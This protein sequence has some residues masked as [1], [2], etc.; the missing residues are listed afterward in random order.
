MSESKTILYFLRNGHMGGS[1]RQTLYLAQGLAGAGYRM[2]CV[3][4]NEGECAERMR[5]YGPVHILDLPPWRSVQ[6]VLK[7][8]RLL[9]KLSA[10]V[11]QYRPLLVH[12]ADV[13]LTPYAVNMARILGI[14]SIVHVRAPLAV[15]D[16]CK[17]GCSLASEVISI[18][19]R[20]TSNL[21]NAGIVQSTITQIYDSV[22]TDFFCPE[23]QCASMPSA[24]IRVGIVGRVEPA[25]RQEIFVRLANSIAN[26]QKGVVFLII[27]EIRDQLYHEK[28][29]QYLSKGG[30]SDKVCF[31][32]ERTDIADVLRGIDVLV[33]F[34]GGSV[35]YEAMACGCVVISA[36]FSTQAFSL[37]Q[38]GVTGYLFPNINIE[39]IADHII[40][41]CSDKQ[42]RNKISRNGYEWIQ[43]HLSV[44]KMQDETYNVYAKALS[45]SQK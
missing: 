17:F 16:I 11:D 2:A 43:Q 31:L 37:I 36:G 6:G 21:L 22:D 41:M 8:K 12:C 13:W 35:I 24:V 20:T 19:P 25:K 9:K 23:G 40:K 15:H 44:Q 5:S 7:R 39:D 27:G 3:F 1:Q 33:S 34:S 28:L 4:C 42:L 10:M 45:Q 18:S 30:I 26:K 29:F 32:G 38:H 14:P